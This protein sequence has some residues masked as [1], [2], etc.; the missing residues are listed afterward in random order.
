MI[1][2]GGDL[3]SGVAIRLHKAGLKLVITELPQPLVVRRLVSFAE[4]IHEGEWTVEGVT[5]EHIDHPNKA[6]DLWAEDRIPVLVDPELETMEDLQPQV[7]VDARMTKRPPE[8]GREIAPLF[9]GLGPGFHG[10][11]NCHAAIETNRG[12]NM[13]RVYWEG[14][15]EEDTGVPGEVGGYRSERVLRSPTSGTLTTHAEIGDLLK[16]GELIAEVDGSSIKAPFSGA[17]RGLLRDKTEVK[18]GTKVGDL[19]PR[20]D[21]SY[22]RIV[23]DK[24]RAV[25]GAVLEAILSRPELRPFLWN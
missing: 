8:V 5:A 24:S 20:G 14:K 9:I 19:D 11:V 4:A 15:P 17:L 23:S 12:H 16:E 10:G 7:V 1:R 21:P 13:G 3:A 2:G 22:S 25:G 18:E 6:K